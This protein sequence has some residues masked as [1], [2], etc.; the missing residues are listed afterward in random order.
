MVNGFMEKFDWIIFM[1]VVLTRS[2][3]NTG[4][5][6][7]EIVKI[8]RNFNQDINSNLVKHIRTK[9]FSSFVSM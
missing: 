7:N 4:N 8:Q 3:L 6:Y 5:F 1:S 9:I 2:V